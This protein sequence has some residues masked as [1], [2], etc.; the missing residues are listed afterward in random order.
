MGLTNARPRM[1]LALDHLPQPDSLLSRLDPRWKLAAFL[2]AALV[3]ALLRTV[4]AA[5]LAMGG[6]VLLVPLARLPLGWYWHRLGSL[7]LFLLV[8][9][10]LLPFVIGD[11]GPGL[12][13]GSLHISWYGLGVAVCL[14]LKALS[15]VTLVLVVLTTAPLGTTLKAA[16]ALY[17][18]AVFVQLIML[19][20][21]YIYVLGAE[22]SRLRIALRV[23]GFRNRASLHSYHTV[24]H[25]AGTLL[26]RG[27]ER[28][29]RVAQAMRCRGFDGRFRSLTK[30]RTTGG[31]VLFFILVAGS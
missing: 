21:R 30:F 11:S 27:Y 7:A 1:T 26:V 8:L 22:L 2:L 9:V 15:L 31:D 12:N 20:H 14:C 18:P 5:I 4:T 23:R 29:E 28:G 16:H 17:V 13:I 24:G 19:T 10:L 6:A 25:V 3:I